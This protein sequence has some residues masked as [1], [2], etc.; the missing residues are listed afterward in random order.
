[1]T[2]A[3][4]SISDALNLVR[5]TSIETQTPGRVEQTVWQRIER[6]DSAFS[7]FFLF[8]LT[9]MFTLKDIRKICQI[10]FTTQ[11]HI[12]LLT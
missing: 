11:K 1:M 12:Y 8:S 4:L 10:M 3:F 5:D 7:F 2:E 9:F 6:S